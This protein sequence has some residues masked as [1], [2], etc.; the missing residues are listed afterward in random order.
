MKKIPLGGMKEVTV[1][2]VCLVVGSAHGSS[3]FCSFGKGQVGGQEAG[4]GSAG[5]KP[6]NSGEQVQREGGWLAAG[7]L[8]P[9]LCGAEAAS[10]RVCACVGGGVCVK[11]ITGK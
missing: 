11:Q 8:T 3:S 5:G 7:A 2:S 6:Q 9:T 1:S 4:P 10:S